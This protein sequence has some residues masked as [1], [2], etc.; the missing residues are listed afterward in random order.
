[1]MMIVV[2][3]GR[4]A[5]WRGRPKPQQLGARRAGAPEGSSS[6]PDGSSG[7]T[8]EVQPTKADLRAAQS[9]RQPGG[10]LDGR[11]AMD[12]SLSF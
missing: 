12:Y 11:C 4:P 9:G 8:S 6:A 1:M 3:V 7:L 2:A 5:W 10:G